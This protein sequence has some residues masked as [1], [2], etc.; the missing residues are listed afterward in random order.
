MPAPEDDNRQYLLGL[1][2]PVLA[3][4]ALLG[5]A[6]FAALSTGEAAQTIPILLAIAF[7]VAMFLW[8]R[9]Y[10]KRRVARMLQAADPSSF[11]RSFAGSMRRIPHGSLFAAANAAT[12]LAFYGR[13]DEAERTLASNSWQGV[14]PF[15]QAQESAARAV[16]AYA[17]G[18]LVEGLDHAVAATHQASLNVAAPGVEKSELAFRMY[19]NLGLALS[20]RATDSTPG[21]LRTAHGELPLLGQIMAAWGL[22]RIAKSRGDAAEYRAMKAFIEKHAPYF[23]PMLESTAA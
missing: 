15:V 21:E 2:R 20:G 17:R 7:T 18:S 5:I 23:T 8:I 11:L 12:I 19:R 9:W 16:I 22:A 14:P 1:W 6:V 13:F 10:Q 3:A 4:C